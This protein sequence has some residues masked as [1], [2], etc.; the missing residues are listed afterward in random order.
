MHAHI[1]GQTE[2]DQL[3]IYSD[4]EIGVCNEYQDYNS[5]CGRI[6]NGHNLSVYIYT[7][8]YNFPSYILRTSSGGGVPFTASVTGEQF[9]SLVVMN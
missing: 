4:G 6:R 8:G 5:V 7:H 1:C 9:S 2:V 3:L